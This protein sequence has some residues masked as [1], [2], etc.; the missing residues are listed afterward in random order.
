VRATRVTLSVESCTVTSASS[1]VQTCACFLSLQMRPVRLRP[2]QQQQQLLQLPPL[3]PISWSWGTLSHVPTAK[4]SASRLIHE[5][6]LRPATSTTLYSH[7][8]FH[9]RHVPFFLH[10]F[11]DL[12][13][14]TVVLRKC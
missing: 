8:P 9:I 11:N 5:S 14:A 7:K 6:T 12:A 13:T 4:D 10:V 2:K 1:V 3:W